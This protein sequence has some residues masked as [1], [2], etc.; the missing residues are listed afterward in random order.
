M[1]PPQISKSNLVVPDL[2]HVD[3]LVVLL[4]IGLDNVRI[5]RVGRLVG[6]NGRPHTRYGLCMSAMIGAQKGCRIGSGTPMSGVG[7]PSQD[8]TG[9]TKGG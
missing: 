4:R 7:S 2:L 8:W 6:G 1:D 3:N 9:S 5:V